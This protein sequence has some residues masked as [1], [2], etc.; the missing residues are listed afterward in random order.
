MKED[1]GHTKMIRWKTGYP[2]LLVYK[3]KLVFKMFFK[4]YIAMLY[5]PEEILIFETL[6][7][8]RYRDAISTRETISLTS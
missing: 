6:T 8:Q 5:R 7:R 3:G 2:Y 1:F 4:K